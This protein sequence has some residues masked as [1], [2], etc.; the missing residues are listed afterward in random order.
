MKP[1]SNDNFKRKVGN[2]PAIGYAL[3]LA[4]KSRNPANCRCAEQALIV[5]FLPVAAAVARRYRRRGVDS[6]DLEQVARLGLVKA[7]RGWEPDKGGLLG[8]LMPTIHGEVKRFFRDSGGVIRIPRSLYE[9]QPR[10][11]TTERALAQQLSRE[12][13][14][15]EIA[16]AAG[17]P[18]LLVRQIKYASGARRPLSMDEGADWLD[19]LS[20]DTA[21]Q[22]L[23]TATLRAVLRPALA[24]L[25]PREQRIIALRFILEQNQAQI[26]TA[27]G[28]SQMHVSRLLT[29]ALGKLRESLDHADQQ[30]PTAA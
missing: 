10:V 19:Y 24:G 26:G 20:S 8:Y 5:E 1:Q 15:P 28:V 17:L 23:L 27:V 11:T 6:D 4:R 13:S 9:A 22:D 7:I 21:E 2:E 30:K 14:I 16:L 12:P 29:T 18:E 3:A 25:S